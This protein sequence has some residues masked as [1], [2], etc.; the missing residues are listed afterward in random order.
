MYRRRAKA[1]KNTVKNAFKAPKEVDLTVKPIPILTP[2]PIIEQ[3]K[4]L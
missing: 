2:S 3:P 4:D 1:P